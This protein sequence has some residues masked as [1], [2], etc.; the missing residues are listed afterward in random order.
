MHSFYIL[1]LFFCHFT[2]LSIKI[3]W[4][5]ML[6]NI[7]TL[8]YFRMAFTNMHPHGNVPHIY[9]IASLY[10]NKN[11][12]RHLFWH[13]WNPITISFKSRDIRAVSWYFFLAAAHH[14]CLFTR[15]EGVEQTYIACCCR[16][17]ANMVREVHLPSNVCLESFIRTIKMRVLHTDEFREDTFDKL[18][19][20]GLFSIVVVSPL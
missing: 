10:K 3:L 2:S 19:R 5:G 15:G 12:T 7:A 8:I 20:Q 13:K 16:D 18:F 14:C 4:N 6:K 17:F 9:N 11:I 1:Y